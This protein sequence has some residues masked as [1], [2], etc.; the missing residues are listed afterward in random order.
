MENKKLLIDTISGMTDAE[1]EEGGL[2]MAHGML[3]LEAIRPGLNNREVKRYH[4]QIAR[5]WRLINLEEDE[6]EVVNTNELLVYSK[7]VYGNR[8]IYPLCKKSR[9]F[10]ELTH[11]KTLSKTDMVKIE[12]LG[13]TFEFTLDPALGDM[14]KKG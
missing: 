7:T 9:I 2:G 13:Y 10:A 3:S 8:F 12:R 4:D 1:L 5:I 11:K 14:V 6:I